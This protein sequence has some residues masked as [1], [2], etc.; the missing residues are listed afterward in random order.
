MVLPIDVDQAIG[1]VHPTFGRC[2]MVGRS[3]LFRGTWCK[4]Y[5]LLGATV[6]K[7][8]CKKYKEKGIDFHGMRD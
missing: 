4:F 2:E 3:E 8:T 1:I 5:F 6:C 7:E